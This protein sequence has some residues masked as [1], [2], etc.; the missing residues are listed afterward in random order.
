MSVEIVDIKTKNKDGT[1][2]EEEILVFE[3]N[4]PFWG[5][6]P[7]ILLSPTYALEFFPMSDM[8][9]YQSLNAISRS[10]IFLSIFSFIIS[11]N[12][13]I[14]FVGAITLL[15]I[16]L[17]YYYKLQEKR[18]IEKFENPALEVISKN[19][20]DAMTFDRPT[21][22]NPFSNV[23][24][25]DIDVNPHK[26]PAPPTFGKDTYNVIMDNAR[27]LVQEQNPD[28]PDIA[29][30]LFRDLGDQ[31]EFEQSLQP[32][33]SSAST[34]IP[35]D[36]AAFAEFCYGDMISCKEGNKFACAR[37]LDRYTN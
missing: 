13:R 10:V 24:V 32:F 18:R 16:Y 14:L 11:R 34:T 33:Y 15:F 21:S 27:Q 30:K 6:D 5:E 31:I 22:A 12:A 29:D 36:Q 19:Q 23:L 25:S 26:R 4:V 2:K 20:V 28:Q 35:N 17:L 9:F 3:K 8:T 1:I 37:N 7:N